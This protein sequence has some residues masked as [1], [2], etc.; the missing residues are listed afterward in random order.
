MAKEAFNAIMAGL[1]EAVA[2]ARGKETGAKE[3]RIA[4]ADV[5]VRAVRE[6]L[7]MS[8]NK[9]AQ[10]FAFSPGTVRN[11]EQHRRRPEGPARVLL[12]I[13]EKEPEAV[14]R[15]LGAL[16]PK[17]AKTRVPRQRTPIRTKPVRK[18]A[19]KSRVTD[20]RKGSAQK[21]GRMG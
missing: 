12:T 13:I 10:T 6:R 16:R 5:D 8:Q 1:T 21:D 19:T 11:W 17:A 9:F 7:G 18:S 15:A 20:L 14:T 2:H 4:V 3:H